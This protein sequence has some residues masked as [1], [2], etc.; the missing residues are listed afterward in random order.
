MS[1]EEADEKAWQGWDVESD[2]SSDEESEGGWMNVDSDGDDQFD[3]SD[4]EDE[5]KS[6][7]PAKPIEETAET[8][9]EEETKRVSTLATTKVRLPLICRTCSC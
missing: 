8:P 9:K 5:K 3:V 2:D 1:D 7:L 6:S 4:S